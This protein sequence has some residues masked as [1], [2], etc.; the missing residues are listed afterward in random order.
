MQI[1]HGTSLPHPVRRA[2]EIDY[3]LSSLDCR[4]TLNCMTSPS[5]WSSG[6]Y[7]SVAEQIAV[8]ADEVVDAVARRLSL[9]DA[10]LV[11]LACGTGNAALTAVAHGARVTAVDI[12][13]ELLE[14]A[15]A[16]PAGDAVTWLTADAS[17]TGLTAGS[18]AAV[19]SNMGIIFVEPVAQVAEL[20]RLLRP[21]GILGFSAW[22]RGPDNPFFDP[23]IEVLGP[24]STS[25]YSSDQWGDPATLTDRLSADFEGIEVESYSYTW[26]FES[27][28]ASLHFVTDESPMHVNVFRYVGDAHDRLITAFEAAF[29]NHADDTG[30]VAFDAPYVV[31][32]ARRR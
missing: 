13:P 14:I 7:E 11:D 22:S 21:G 5:I 18:Y 32:T 3:S 10:A 23:V 19:V 27:L 28:A 4:G 26:R 24:P 17:A 9:R 31:V 1:R 2:G 12:T 20:A 16:K 25:A 29:A 30:R 15:A 8:I 6:R